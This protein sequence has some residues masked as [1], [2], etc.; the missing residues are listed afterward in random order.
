M[1]TLTWLFP[2]ASSTEPLTLR[3]WIRQGPAATAYQ[4]SKWHDNRRAG[5]A[6]M[7]SNSM[8]GAHWWTFSYVSRRTTDPTFPPVHR[9]PAALAHYQC[10]KYCQCGKTDSIQP[11]YVFAEGQDGRRVLHWTK[12]SLV[13]QHLHPFS[14]S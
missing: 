2:L 11:H 3:L 13:I 10:M 9:R 7:C 1:V 6:Y 4:N 12:T 14:L 5:Q 8:E